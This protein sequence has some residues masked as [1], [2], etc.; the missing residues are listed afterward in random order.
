MLIEEIM[1]GLVF[2]DGL[3]SVFAVIRLFIFNKDSVVDRATLFT[4]VL[5]N[6]CTFSLML[7]S[8]ADHLIG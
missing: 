4:I 8:I 6:L 5:L 1:A 7:A 2:I 3:L